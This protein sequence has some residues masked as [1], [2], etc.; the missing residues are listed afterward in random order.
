MV[1]D[2]PRL[3]ISARYCL[4]VL[5]RGPRTYSAS[6]LH[7]RVL[8]RKGLAEI[9]S[10]EAKEGYCRWRIT[11]A[12]RVALKSYAEPHEIANEFR[13]EQS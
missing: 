12:G 10:G 2:R 7:I 11:E 8:A 4:Q 13:E 3:S 1:V 6:N 9:A 5:S